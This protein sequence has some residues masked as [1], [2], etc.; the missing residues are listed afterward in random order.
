MTS[1]GKES[2][3]VEH[4]FHEF[5]DTW[6]TRAPLYSAIASIVA[7][8]PHLAGLLLR[9]PD[10]QRLPVLLFASVHDLL[11]GD[12]TAELARWYPNLDDE[13]RSPADPALATAFRSF[14][15]DHDE[16]V[17]ERL[18]SRSTQT[19]EIGRC[20]LLL[21]AFGL[22]GDEVG[23]IGHLDIGAS[24]GLNLLLDRYEYHYIDRDGVTSTVGSSPV[25]I[26][27]TTRGE[28]P[29]PDL[30][31]IVSSRLG[32][33]RHPVDVMNAGEARWLEA[34]VW[35][36]HL[37]R[38][39]RLSAAIELARTEPPE[40]LVGDAVTSLRRAIERF[41]DDVHPVVTN[42]WVLNY[43]TAQERIDYLAELDAIGAERDI[44]WV[45]AEAPILVPELPSE[46]DPSNPDLTVLSLARWRSGV[47]SVEHLATCHPHG[48]SIHWR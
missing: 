26:P 11:L 8:D 12:P 21:P 3:D 24:G 46:P 27:I 23:S 16:L 25:T 34:C 2:G 37:E 35:P 5:A 44:S 36:D 41:G 14:V 9:A 19:N 18:Q 43:L 32:V 6:R 7:H 10:T 39:E 47:R 42:T 33:D 48:R 40:V 30:M 1:I 38:F 45:Y 31:P 13:P 20:G 4:S 22:I 17:T 28:V 29:V 15:H